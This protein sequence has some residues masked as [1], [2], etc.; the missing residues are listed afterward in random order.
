MQHKRR[1]RSVRVCLKKLQ[2][3]NFNMQLSKSKQYYDLVFS[4]CM[5]MLRSS[6]KR[7]KN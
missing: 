7:L 5:F 1:G 3:S 2:N 6:L 4:I